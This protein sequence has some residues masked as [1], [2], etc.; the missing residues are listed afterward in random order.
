MTLLDT[1]IYDKGLLDEVYLLPYPIDSGGLWRRLKDITQK[2]RIDGLMP[3][4]DLELLNMPG[5]EPSLKEMGINLLLP[6]ASGIKTHFKINLAEFCL[7]NDIKY[8]RQV[9]ISSPDWIASNVMGLG[10]P[11]V[12]KSIVHE[13]HT[14]YSVEEALVYFNKI[15]I[16]WGLP[17]L[18]Q[19][20]IPGEEYNTD[21]L[22]NRERKLI[23]TVA[24]RKLV[25][26]E[27]GKA[28]SGVTVRDEELLN[29]SKEILDKLSWTGQ[30][31]LDFVK[32][33]T[34]GNYYLLEIN[35]RF[36][37]WIYLASN[38]GQNL[39]LASIQIAMGE[40]VEPLPPYRSGLMFVRR[41]L[42]FTCPIEYLANLTAK[43]ELVLNKE[44][45]KE[46]A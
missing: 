9:A 45:N 8:P 13:S 36:G 7:K 18:L 5:L 33:R 38:A 22:I 20:Y 27:K 2:T 44:K 12:V 39:P 23:G 19:E 42:D 4:L 43:G 37:S 31:E 14:A 28:W 16:R 24:M 41:S 32:H 29:L 25:I 26:T 17:V 40:R 34:S 1:G 3:L 30:A 10:I 15:K 35:P 6:P 21:C 46:S 11:V